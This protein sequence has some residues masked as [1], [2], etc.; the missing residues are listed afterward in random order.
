MGAPDLTLFLE[1][2]KCVFFN[3][4]CIISRKLDT[5]ALKSRFFFNLMIQQA[6]YKGVECI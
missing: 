6:R 1:Q 5:L 2:T 3:F 4:F